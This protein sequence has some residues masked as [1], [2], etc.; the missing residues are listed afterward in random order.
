MQVWKWLH[1]PCIRK[2]NSTRLHLMQLLFLLI[3]ACIAQC[4]CFPNCTRIHVIRELNFSFRLQLTHYF[5]LLQDPIY[6]LEHSIP[7]D[8]SYYLENQLAKPLLR[9]FEP[10]LGDSRAKQELLSEYYIIQGVSSLLLHMHKLQT[11]Y[12]RTE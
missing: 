9:I 10:I 7:I 1:S 4:N 3:H 12:I 8:T 11:C 2:I 6:V 5:F